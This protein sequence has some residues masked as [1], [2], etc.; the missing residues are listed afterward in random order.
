LGSVLVILGVVVAIIVLREATMTRH[1]P[2]DRD[3]EMH[4]VVEASSNVAGAKL[5]EMVGALFEMCQLEVATDPIGPPSDLGAG[6][7]LL[8]MRPALDDGDRRQIVGC[9]EDAKIDRL[10]AG[11]RE[12]RDV[13][14][15]GVPS[16]TVGG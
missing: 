10:Q 7:F 13:R 8:R 14:P 2:V 6:T 15:T 16:T 9:L 5:P 11:V 1:T 4:V 3:T 12:V